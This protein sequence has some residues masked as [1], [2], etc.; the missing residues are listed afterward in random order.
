M[1]IKSSPFGEGRGGVLGLLKRLC[2]EP[3]EAVVGVHTDD[4]TAKGQVVRVAAVQWVS[5]R[6]PIVADEANEVQLTI[7]VVTQGGQVEV[8][9]CVG[10][11]WE[12]RVVNTTIAVVI[13]LVRCTHVG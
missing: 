1:C 3:V 6:R 4:T 13:A 7:V 5:T 9:A 11:R 10:Y 2:P 12:A 8:V